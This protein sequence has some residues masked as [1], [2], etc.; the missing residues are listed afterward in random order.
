MRILTMLAAL[1][2]VTATATAQDRPPPVSVPHAEGVVETLDIGFPPPPEESGGG[3]AGPA[4][5]ARSF[6]RA[7]ANGVQLHF[8]GIG[9]D[10][11]EFFEI[12]LVD[13]SGATV[14]TL[15]RETL[16]DRTA[17][18]SNI[19]RGQSLG[20]AVYGNRNGSLRFSID[21]ISFDRLGMVLESIVG[22]DGREHLYRY[23]GDFAPVVDR[24]QGAVAKL[25]F[26]K[27][28]GDGPARYVCTGFL[29][30]DDT[31]VSNEHC[32]ADADTCATAKVIFGFAYNSLGQTPGIEQYDCAS[33]AAVNADLDVAVLKLAGT[34]GPR[35]GT[36]TLASNDLMEDERLFV[37]QHP[38]GE[39]KQISDEGCA[40]FEA[41]SPGRATA[42]D[43]AHLCD[44]L[45]GSSGS[46]V[47]D[48]EGEVVGLHH[49]GRAA[50]GK[51]SGSNRAVRIGPIHEFLAQAGQIPPA[52]TGDN[53]GEGSSD[54]D[55]S[56]NQ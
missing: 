33:V 24:V 28:E 55:D 42:S 3:G 22:A 15:T 21:A 14:Q 1:A 19:G 10:P 34:P 47:F 35:W 48:A 11:E 45:G 36:L 46:P 20:V 39:A 41:Q 27:D 6:L 13:T 12:E 2:A 9:F 32:V 51:Y 23:H 4:Q 54:G 25:S 38:A 26:I 7:G 8:S 56:V 44:T 30:G 37:L 50:F 31:F 16:G 29:I 40:V 52:A 43:F 5:W 18:W 17:L 53:V 49:W